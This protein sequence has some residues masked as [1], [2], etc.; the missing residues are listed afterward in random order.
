MDGMQ[1]NVAEAE[2]RGMRYVHLPLG[3]DGI[4][5]PRCAELSRAVRDLPK[6]IYVHCHHG[7][8]RGPAATA[9]ALV[10]LG[11]MTP[12]QAVAWMKSAGTS[13]SY[14]GLFRD[15]SHAHRLSD[16]ELARASSEFP[17]RAPVADLARAM[18]TIDAAWDNLA[19][20]RDAGWTTPPAHPDLALR[21]EATIISEAFREAGRIDSPRGAEFRARLRQ[22]EQ[23]AQELANAGGS[24]HVALERIHKEL[25][26][27]CQSCHRDFRD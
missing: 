1:P 5:A 20:I 17:S 6:P 18:S 21:A 25:A 9:A 22:A 11:R 14:A 13:P 10:G 27:Q 23:A 16:A 19:R 15:V 8:H 3:Y 7:L 26:A 4:P 2:Q 12:D 24:E